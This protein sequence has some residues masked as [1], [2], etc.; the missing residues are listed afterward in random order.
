MATVPLPFSDQGGEMTIED[1]GS[2]VL[3]HHGVKGMKWGVRKAAT[4][5]S[6][7]TPKGRKAAKASVAADRQAHASADHKEVQAHLEKAK[8]HG[9]SA[10]SNADLRKVNDRLNLEQNFSRMSKP[11]KHAGKKFAE[12]LLKQEGQ[13]QIRRIAAKQIAKSVAK[14]AA[15][16]ALL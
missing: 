16:A 11:Q 2:V 9:T 1:F 4:R 12:D 7:S 5:V 15:V 3:E 6:A 14:K 8:T 10:L 13:Q